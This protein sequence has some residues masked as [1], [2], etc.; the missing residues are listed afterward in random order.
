MLTAASPL[1]ALSSCVPNLLVNLHGHVLAMN[2]L[3]EELLNL[4]SQ[5]CLMQPI[6]HLCRDTLERHMLYRTVADSS[7][8]DQPCPLTFHFHT[9]PGHYVAV[10]IQVISMAAYPEYVIVR[11]AD[12]NALPPVFERALPQDSAG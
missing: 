4:S 3:A 2:T 6:F 8:H 1:P 5:E 10:E 7:L 12:I 9:Q 11:L